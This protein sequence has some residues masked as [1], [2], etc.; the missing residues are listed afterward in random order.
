MAQQRDEG[1]KVATTG[2]VLQQLTESKNH[3]PRPFSLR[4]TLREKDHGEWFL[5]TAVALHMG[6]DKALDCTCMIRSNDRDGTTG[7]LG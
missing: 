5:L 7:A 6:S 2:V 1:P 4:N 3:S